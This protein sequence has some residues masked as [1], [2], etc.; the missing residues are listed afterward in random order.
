MRASKRPE[1]A[2]FCSASGNSSAPQLVTAS[3]DDM[4]SDDRAV[5]QSQAPAARPGNEGAERSKT[6][7]A[8]TLAALITRAKSLLALGDIAGARLRLSCW[9][10]PMIRLC[11]ECATREA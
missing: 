4:A 9:H 11:S 5:L 6:L 7:D 10:K 3:R 2:I 1:F 8:E